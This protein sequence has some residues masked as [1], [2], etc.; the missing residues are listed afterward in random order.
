[1]PTP[2]CDAGARKYDS[3]HEHQ[4]NRL[5]ESSQAKGRRELPGERPTHGNRSPRRSQRQGDLERH[6]ASRNNCVHDR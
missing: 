2:E 5:Q 1:M 4:H 3:G 6:D